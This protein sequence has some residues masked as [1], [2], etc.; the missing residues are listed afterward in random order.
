M[1]EYKRKEDKKI[2]KE[3]IVITL[4]EPSNIDLDKGKIDMISNN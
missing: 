3:A 4:M 2:R 1:K